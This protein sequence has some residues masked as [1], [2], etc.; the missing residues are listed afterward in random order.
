MFVDIKS[1]DIL[2]AQLYTLAS[3]KHSWSHGE[4]N[5]MIVLDNEDFTWALTE[6][7]NA[8]AGR[9]FGAFNTTYFSMGL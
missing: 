7:A 1:I 2:P 9:N 3:S 4:R 8:W 5:M 6:L